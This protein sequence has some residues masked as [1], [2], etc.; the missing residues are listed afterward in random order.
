MTYIRDHPDNATIQASTARF[1]IDGG[2]AEA[3]AV[4]LACDLVAQWYGNGVADII[5]RAPRAVYDILTDL[6]DITAVKIKDTIALVIPT[7]YRLDE[8]HI[9]AELVTAD[10]S[11]RDDLLKI[12]RGEDVSNQAVNAAGVHIRT[13]NNLRFR[14]QSEIRIASALEGLGVM[15]LPNCMAR[16]STPGGRA[17]READFL[18][19]DNGRMGILEVDGEPFHPPSRTVHDHERDRLFRSY[20]ITHIEHYDA[21]RCYDDA[22]GVVTEFL[23]LLRR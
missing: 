11:W 9:R 19:I 12:A 14:S 10:E 15:F 22:A 21:N 1:L 13:W 6:V 2:E 7:Y 18:I 23:A 20:G 4:L 3:A 17:N 16:L 5:L 8:F